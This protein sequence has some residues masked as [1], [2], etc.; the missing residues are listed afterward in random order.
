MQKAVGKIL[1]PTTGPSSGAGRQEEKAL[2]GVAEAISDESWTR[3][4]QASLSSAADM[5]C[6]SE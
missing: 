5:L 6:D 4:P 1:T 2:Q 3:R